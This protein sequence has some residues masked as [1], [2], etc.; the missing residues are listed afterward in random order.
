GYFAYNRFNPVRTSA[1]M[2]RVSMRTTYW[3]RLDFAASYT[4][5]S[6]DMN[7]PL[8]EFFN[9]LTTRT[10]TRQSAVTGFG[11]ATRVSN[12]ADFTATLHLN[13]HLR[14]VDTFRYWAFRI[15]E[16]FSATETDWECTNSA[17]CSLLTPLSATTQSAPALTLD[18]ISFNQSLL[19]NEMD[20]V[21]DS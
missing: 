8:S 20:L 11:N 10:S 3:Q 19:K 5:G 17:T 12:V 14:L 16:N 21:W 6:A 15:P 2:E 9:G 4:Y 1:P 7:A 13:E 18:Q